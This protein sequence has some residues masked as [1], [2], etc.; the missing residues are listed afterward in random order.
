MKK[1]L[2]SLPYLI[3]GLIGFLLAFFD[4][5]PESWS[6]LAFILAIISFFVFIVLHVAIHELGHLVFGLLTGYKFGSIRLFSW[7]LIKDGETIKFRRME[8]P[9]TL[10]QCLM[11]P[12]KGEF[13]FKLSILGGGIANIVV[14]LIPLFIAGFDSVY[15]WIFAVTGLFIGISNLI[16]MSFNDGMTYRL[17][18]SSKEQKYLLYLQL[19]IN[20]L[21]TQGTTITE[22]PEEYFELV[23]QIPQRTYFNDWQ[24]FLILS[25]KLFRHDWEGYQKGIEELWVRKDELVLPYQ[26]ELKKELL[27]CLS[28]T[29]P[30]DLRIKEIW[31]DKQLQQNLKMP[32]LGNDRIRAAYMFGVMKNNYGAQAIL[33]EAKS[34]VDQSPNRGDALSELELFDELINYF[35]EGE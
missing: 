8:V 13:Y 5:I 27:F 17:A 28:L 19:Q 24:E 20:Y 2:K 29:T 35:K 4:L 10:G 7:M 12:P 32:L 33:K 34:K 21:T 15:A 1:I 22:L 14:A 16:P 23:P 31:S 26:I 18:N 6:G 25:R 30:S 9:G 3:G 11:V